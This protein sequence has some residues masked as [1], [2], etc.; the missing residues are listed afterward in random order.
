MKKHTICHPLDDWA[1]GGAGRNQ[2]G[3]GDASPPCK[4]VLGVVENDG[5]YSSLK[6]LG[7][8]QKTLRHPWC[9]KLVTG[10]RRC[11]AYS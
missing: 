11:K 2:G 4:N 7:P 1:E 5:T 10:L 6:N 9:P 3:A 8:S